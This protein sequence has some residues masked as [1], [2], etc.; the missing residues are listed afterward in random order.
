MVPLPVGSPPRR[1]T[2]A[3]AFARVG[4]VAEVG[5][6]SEDGDTLARVGGLTLRVQPFGLE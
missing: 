3:A 4:D 5:W 2:F 1:G 6:L